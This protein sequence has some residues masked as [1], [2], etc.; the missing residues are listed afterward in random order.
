[1]A[2]PHS[3]VTNCPAC[4][5]ADVAPHPESTLVLRWYRCPLCDQQWSV[6]LRG[7][8]TIVLVDGVGDPDDVM[9]LR[10]H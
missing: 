5:L 4:G 9:T 1:M 8:E 3:I 6:R 10:R 7:G 2:E